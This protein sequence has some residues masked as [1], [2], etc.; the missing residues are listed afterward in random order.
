VREGLQQGE[1]VITSG[2]GQM[3]DV[4]RVQLNI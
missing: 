3:E 1:R 2:Y 4:E